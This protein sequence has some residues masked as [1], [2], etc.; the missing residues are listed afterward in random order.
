M[1][2]NERA[3]VELAVRS[4]RIGPDAARELR[5]LE[6]LVA[7]AGLSPAEVRSL[8]DETVP[9]SSPDETWP[10]VAGVSTV[11]L[12]PDGSP[13]DGAEEAGPTPR[14][15]GRYFLFERIGQGG[16][17]AVWRAWQV[18]LGRW[19]AVKI[20]RGGTRTERAR[21]LR[22]AELASRL[23]HPNI[24]ATYEASE[25]AGF[26]YIAMQLV[27]GNDLSRA[28][29]SER[30]ALGIVRQAAHAVHSAHEHGVVHRD[31]KPR[32]LLLGEGDHVY[33]SDFGLAR[34]LAAPS[35]LSV[36]G[37][38]LGT[39]SYMSPEQA[40]GQKADAR[41]DV[42]G[43]GA[44]LYELLTGRPPLRGENAVEIL[45]RVGTEE[46]VRPRRIDPRIHRDAETIA[47]KCLEK[48]PSRRYATARELAEDLERALAGRP[49]R[50]RP[51]G[52][53]GRLFRRARRN[54][55]AAGLACVLVLGVL[56]G[57]IAWGG[58]AYTRAR[59]V[60][61][62]LEEAGEASPER[63][64]AIYEDLSRIAPEDE[65]IRDRRSALERVRALVEEARVMGR[66]IEEDRRRASELEA[67]AGKLATTIE[68][69]SPLGEKERLWEAEDRLARARARAETRSR[70]RVLLL[71]QALALEPGHPEARALLAR[72]WFA[73][74][75]EAERSRDPSAAQLCRD[76]VRAYDDGSLAGRLAGTGRLSLSTG[77][78][79]AEA[80]ACP[81]VV[82][83]R[84]LEIDAARSIPLGSTPIEGAS[85]PVGS[86][87]I[88]LSRPGQSD[89]LYPVR[90]ER[91]GS[92]TG[93][94]RLPG[95]EA[96]DER[97]VFVPAGPY[98][99]GG[100]SRAPR[101]APA[102]VHEASGFHIGRFEV[103][104]AEYLEFL[105]DLERTAPDEARNRRPRRP[106]GTPLELPPGGDRTPARGVSWEDA[107]AYCEWLSTRDPRWRYRLPTAG[108]WEKAARGVDG[109]CFPWGDEFDWAFAKGYRSRPGPAIPEDVGSFETDVSPYGVR[110]LAGG[111]S[112]WC[113]D[114]F[115]PG[116]RNLRGGSWAQM[117]PDEFRAAYRFGGTPRYAGENL[118]LRLVREPRS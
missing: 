105:A 86:H 10:N 74:L 79:P 62:L 80:A 55:P 91:D 75:L 53:A 2:P 39:P 22:E 56:G 69:G 100:D 108:E 64:L 46:P 47:L 26:P 20:L 66:E 52:F 113:E 63:K 104:T 106:G 48:D 81:V 54:P 36:T 11:L 3:I 112:E 29:L 115:S 82:E 23:S 24:V 116:L 61:R 7:R 93:S 70:E 51:V 94:I 45:S 59:R 17:G 25:A 15:L 16:M 19:V 1:T 6:D 4:G 111:V 32:N 27:R 84:R 99:A 96:E 76:E 114:E 65:A 58:R 9:P 85:L 83:V 72:H 33:V 28:H 57:A 89:V 21:F 12:A 31:I 34:S 77:G 97:F 98:L 68:E 35:E 37:M 95:P 103:T 50:A 87:V 41:A 110:D 109:R 88:V 60:S 18:D 43:L 5:G 42:Y 101:S 90:I 40:L 67:E 107:R 71:V 44:T 8:L 78:E 13:D 73:E 118:G 14:W 117:L 92:W 102:A 30:R 38:I 49:L